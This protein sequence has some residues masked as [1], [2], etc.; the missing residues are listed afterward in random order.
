MVIPSDKREE[1]DLRK[2]A[3]SSIKAVSNR[4]LRDRDPRPARAK[5]PQREV[6][7]LFSKRNAPVFRKEVLTQRMGLILIGVSLAILAVIFSVFVALSQQR[8]LKS[9][10]DDGRSLVYWVALYTEKELGEGTSHALDELGDFVEVID[11]LGGKTG[12]LYAMITDT[13]GQ[14][15]AHTEAAAVGERRDDAVGQRAVASNNP[16]QQTYHDPGIGAEVHEFSRPVFHNGEK[17]WVVRVGLSTATNPLLSKDDRRVLS[18]V[19]MLVFLLVPIF[20]YLLRNFLRPLTAWNDELADLLDK[21]EIRKIRCSERGEVGEVVR[22]FNGVLSKVSDRYEN[23]QVALDEVEVSNRIL[24]YEKDRIESIVDNLKDAILVTNSARNI[25][26]VN[27]EMEGFLG[28]DRGAALGKGLEECLDHG[29]ILALVQRETPQGDHFAE[30]VVELSVESSGGEHVFRATHLPLL[31]A[32]DDVLGSMIVVRDVTAQKLT[33]RNQAEFIAHVSHELKTPLTTMKSYVELLMDGEISDEKTRAEFFNT[34]SGETDRLARLIDNLLN[35]SKIEMGS[36]MIR[37][38]LL[39]SRE[40]FEDVIRSVESQAVSKGVGLEAILPDKLSD[41]LVDKDLFRVAVLN[42]LSNAIKYTP[43]GG[44]VVFRVDE[45]DER[46]KIEIED[47]GYGISEE[48]LPRIFEKFYRSANKEIRH[49]TGS[50]L[51]LALS[52][53]IV[54]LH[55]GE[56]EVTSRLEEGTCFSLRLPMDEKPRLKGFEGTFSALVNP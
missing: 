12:L 21:N 44:H 26:L 27:R 34:I 39:K 28:L 54:A 42:I 24:S 3:K 29:E 20:Y 30:K 52:K 56:I 19:A 2:D 16:L 40:L 51:G 11:L 36:L 23:L 41:L 15:L 7:A 53:E 25:I 31:N 32:G 38:N 35:I 49:Q 48:E 33:D 14:V 37:K 50:G 8:H 13:T 47:S 5:G 55:N 17:L 6:V 46:M 1:R 4:A 9:L 22:R 18:V 43:P 45:D 10:M